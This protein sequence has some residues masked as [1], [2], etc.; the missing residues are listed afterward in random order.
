[1][2]RSYL[3]TKYFRC[4]S[5]SKNFTLVLP[6]CL[7][8]S[9]HRKAFLRKA[10][11]VCNGDLGSRYWKTGRSVSQSYRG[12]LGCP[13]GGRHM[14]VIE[15]ASEKGFIYLIF[16]DI[17][18]IRTRDEAVCRQDT[19]LEYIWNGIE[20]ESLS[21]IFLQKSGWL[22]FFCLFSLSIPSLLSHS[23]PS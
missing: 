10:R 8:S 4:D 6:F 23:H 15:R 16:S 11:D 17:K 12:E 2:R 14:N 3:F 13:G 1:M 18:C 19:W 20:L 5:D 7:T 9:F 21:K 22:L